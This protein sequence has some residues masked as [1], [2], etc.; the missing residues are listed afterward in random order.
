[1][2]PQWRESRVLSGPLISLNTIWDEVP[3]SVVSGYDEWEL[4]DGWCGLVF[5]VGEDLAD[6]L[7]F[8]VSSSWW[9]E[10]QKGSFESRWCLKTSLVERNLEEWRWN[11]SLFLM[12]NEVFLF[13]NSVSEDEL[14]VSE[15]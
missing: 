4:E 10:S 15:L 7:N 9:V 3:S 11:K 1:M 5:K 13:M 12:S 2:V 14:E 6:G 8:S